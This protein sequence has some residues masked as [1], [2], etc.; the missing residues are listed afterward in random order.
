MPRRCL[1]CVCAGA[2]VAAYRFVYTEGGVGCVWGGGCLCG[3]IF[4]KAG[5]QKAGSAESISCRLFY[6][7][8]HPPPHSS[9]AS[10]RAPPP[11][12]SVI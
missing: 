12:S 6:I 10:I 1:R 5:D 9:P 7:P 2:D 3:L 8:F 11:P 4:I